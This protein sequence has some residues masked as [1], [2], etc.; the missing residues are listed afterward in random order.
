[1]R[2]FVRFVSAVAV[3]V[4]VAG[5]PAMAETC[6]TD[7][8]EAGPIVKAEGLVSAKEIQELARE[9]VGGNLIKI[10]LCED[11][12][13]FTYKLVVDNDGELKDVT[14]DARAPFVQ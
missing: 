12:G 9:Q 1:M 8:T 13:S 14:V 5:S 3:A 4:L 11:A 2:G 10:T 7:W 6:Y